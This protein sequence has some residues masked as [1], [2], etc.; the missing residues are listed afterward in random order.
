[1][2]TNT[3]VPVCHFKNEPSLARV[4]FLKNHSV[5]VGT[6]FKLQIKYESFLF[7]SSSIQEH[8][9]YEYLDFHE[10]NATFYWLL[11]E[12][13]KINATLCWKD[14]WR[15]FGSMNSSPNFR[16][17]CVTFL[18]IFFTRGTYIFNTPL[19]LTVCLVSLLLLL[20]SLFKFVWFQYFYSYSKLWHT[21]FVLNKKPQDKIT[22]K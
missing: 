11:H 22:Q 2:Q 8:C 9:R 3:K 1:M 5:L 14:E 7:L 10:E 4:I 15:H 18:P 21:D 20:F 16:L 17:W 6:L 13:F 12:R 19:A